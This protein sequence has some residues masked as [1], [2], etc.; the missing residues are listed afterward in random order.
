MNASSFGAAGG[1]TVTNVDKQ[2]TLVSSITVN[3]K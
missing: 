3:I 1:I 2:W